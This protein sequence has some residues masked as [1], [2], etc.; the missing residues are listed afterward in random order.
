[1]TIYEVCKRTGLTERTIL[2]YEEEGLI[3]PE[4]VEKDG[5]VHRNYSEQDVSWLETISLLRKL[6]FS[7]DEIKTMIQEPNLIPTVL[8]DYR[9]RIICFGSQMND[10]VEAIDRLDM[11]YVPDVVALSKGLKVVAAKRPLQT[12]DLS[13]NVHPVE[14]RNGSPDISQSKSQNAAAKA[15]QNVTLNF[16]RIDDIEGAGSKARRVDMITE[17]RNL[18]DK[19]EKMV[20]AIIAVDIV[21]AVLA[22]I[23]NFGFAN[24]VAVAISILLAVG[25]F[26][27]KTWVQ[28]VYVIIFGIN[29]FTNLYYLLM[30]PLTIYG[31]EFGWLKFLIAAL[32]IWRIINIVWLTKS[33]SVKE[34]LDY[35]R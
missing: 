22:L 27:G 18:I 3:S 14:S 26:N 29:I 15:S 35:K 5:R 31:V 32:I 21:S 12:H 7:V 8:S 28:V 6:S 1:M 33:R 4:K 19:G 34:F 11:K 25:L 17:Q 9:N 23:L 2:Y 24:I 20:T 10:V 13:P 16:G 30:F